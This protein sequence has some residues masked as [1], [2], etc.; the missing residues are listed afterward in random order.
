MSPGRGRRAGPDRP[1]RRRPADSPTVTTRARCAFAMPAHQRV[2][3]VEHR[4]AAVRRGGQRLDELALRL[5]DRLPRAELAE[6][7]AADV[8]HDPDPGRGDL[9]EVRM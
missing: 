7:C 8:E 6:V 1:A 4:D 2:V 9:G 3:G 5:R